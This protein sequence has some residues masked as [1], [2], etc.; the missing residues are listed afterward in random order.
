MKSN[1][2][3]SHICVCIDS[4]TFFYDVLKH[5]MKIQAYFNQPVLFS[6][7]TKRGDNKQSVRNAAPVLFQFNE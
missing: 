3:K 1:Q 2:M 7:L 6:K 5:C 4:L